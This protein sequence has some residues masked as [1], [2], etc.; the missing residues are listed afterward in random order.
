[1]TQLADLESDHSLSAIH[2]ADSIRKNKVPNVRTVLIVLSVRG[3]ALDVA[4]LKQKVQ[5]AYPGTEVYFM[6]T[7]GK[8]LGNS[9]P[10]SVDLLIDLSGP[11]TR[12][13][14]FFARRLRRRARV[15][16]GRASSTFRKG[17]YDRVVEETFN[18]SKQDILIH[19]REVQRKVLAS[20]GVAVIQAGDTHADRGKITPMELPPFKRL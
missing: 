10:T 14:L 13:G 5:L 8:Y 3:M 9:A 11:G 16:V 15:A 12:Q 2:V 4:S 19:E 20:A 1:M 17:A 7:L 6:T 18:S